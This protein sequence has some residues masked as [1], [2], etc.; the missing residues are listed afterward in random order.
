MH[1][2][3]FSSVITLAEFFFNYV[4]PRCLDFLNIMLLNRPPSVFNIFLILKAKAPEHVLQ[5]DLHAE[6]GSTAGSA[7][8][9]SDMHAARASNARGC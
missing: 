9:D 5:S 6:M 8:N 3:H 1:V 2:S 4:Y 7:C